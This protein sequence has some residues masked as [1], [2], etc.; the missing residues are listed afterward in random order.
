MQ[1]VIDHVINQLKRKDAHCNHA[2]ANDQTNIIVHS[3]SQYKVP[4]G[5]QIECL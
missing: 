3:I 2:N 4:S 5:V 1:T